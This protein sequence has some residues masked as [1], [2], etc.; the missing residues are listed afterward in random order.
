MRFLKD[1]FYI[2]TFLSLTNEIAAAKIQPKIMTHPIANTVLAQFSDAYGYKSKKYIAPLIIKALDQNALAS[3]CSK[4]INAPDVYVASR[5][6]LP[7]DLIMCNKEGINDFIELRMGFGGLLVLASP[8]LNLKNISLP[9]L[10]KIVAKFDYKNGLVIPNTTQRWGDISQNGDLLTSAPI[11]IFVPHKSSDLR[12]IFE[13]RI[14][15]EGCQTLPHI[16]KINLANPKLYKELCLD[17]RADNVLTE[18]NLSDKESIPSVLLARKKGRITFAPL[19]AF[20]QP[21]LVKNLVA[22]NGFIPTID[23]IK[24]AKYPLSAPIYLYVKI[25]SLKATP[26]LQSF[27]KY[28][29]SIQNKDHSVLD[30]TGYVPLSPEE[31]TE[32]FH[33]VSQG[34]ANYRLEELPSDNTPP[35]PTQLQN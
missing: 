14:L 15:G 19:S 26:A 33:L 5:K 3:F 13:D 29:Y 32:Q 1:Y 20:L 16:T 8:S 28:I 35:L 31:M 30:A 24:N 7:E 18:I 6:L 17:T 23:T 27:L 12:D 22:I 25:S 9:D 2:L 11:L 10:Y 4:K 21:D 34:K